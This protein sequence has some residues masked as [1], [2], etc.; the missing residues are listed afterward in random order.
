MRS[1]LCIFVLAAAPLAALQAQVPSQVVAPPGV[2]S[3][4]VTAANISA[5]GGTV[6]SSSPNFLG[7]ACGAGC[8]IATASAGQKPSVA[9]HLK[10][11]G[12]H[13]TEF[14]TGLLVSH[15]VAHSVEVTLNGGDIVG[16]LCDGKGALKVSPHFA[17]LGAAPGFSWAVFDGVK[18]VSKGHSG[19][20]AALIGSGA[21]GGHAAMAPMELAISDRAVIEIV[22][23]GQRLVITPDDQSSIGAKTKGYLPFDDVA[24]SV[25]GPSSFALV[26]PN[27]N[28]GL[29]PPGI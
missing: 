3:R 9:L 13:A 6:T 5:L 16:L 26:K 7:A 11:I 15:D 21:A 4:V 28:F 19:G 8:V 29:Q 18:L 14:R 10:G 27:L 25:G 1:A 12:A 23:G 22:H 2:S 20:E 17:T 24:V